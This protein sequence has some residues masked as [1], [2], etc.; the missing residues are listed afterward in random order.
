MRHGVA[1]SLL[2]C[3]VV[4]VLGSLA[5]HL[6][7]GTVCLSA[8]SVSGCQR[9]CQPDNLSET[10]AQVPACSV[11]CCTGLPRAFEVP[12]PRVPS[13]T[14]CLPRIQDLSVCLAPAPP[15]PKPSLSICD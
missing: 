10:Q 15:P 1:R 9:C 13:L 14:V 3:C 2:I 4:M 5:L 12:I 11:F 8:R 7:A 6:V